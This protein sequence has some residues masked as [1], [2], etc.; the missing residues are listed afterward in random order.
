MTD[1]AEV[2]RFKDF[3]VSPE[4]ISFRME[5]DTFNCLPDIPLDLLMELAEFATIGREQGGKAQAEKMKEFFDGILDEDSAGR[6]RERMKKGAA[7][8]VGKRILVDVLPWLL[9]VYGLR[10]TQESSESAD[11]SDDTATSS[12]A[13]AS[14]EE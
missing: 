6:L 2:V 1:A 13:G 8:P 11:G 14:P 12:T 10:P 9:E 5:D 7:Q 4:P 3:S